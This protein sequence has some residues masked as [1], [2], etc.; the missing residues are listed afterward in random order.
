[1]DKQKLALRLLEWHG[2]QDTYLYSVGSCWYSNLEATKEA[3]SGS[4]DEIDS[5]IRKKV[6][7]PNGISAKDVKSLKCMKEQL[8]K[9]LSEGDI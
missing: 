4:I 3:I 6:L 7:F 8:Q 2:G 1:M 5:L 9:E